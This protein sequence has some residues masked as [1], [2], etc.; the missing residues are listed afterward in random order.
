MMKNFLFTL[1]LFFLMSLPIRVLPYHDDYKHTNQSRSNWLLTESEITYYVAGERVGYINYIKVPLAPVYVLYS[2]YIYPLYRNKGL[3]KR[4]FAYVCD[5]LHGIGARR[6]YIQPGPFE[7]D[8]GNEQIDIT[9]PDRELKLKRLIRF[10][11]NN[12]FVFV[13]KAL[14]FFASF[15]YKCIGISEN[16]QYLMVKVI[17]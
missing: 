7:L 16:P 5:Y 10:Y 2:F 12:D 4:L 11:K 1:G 9:A 8:E 13:N 3:G 15:L 6:I 14:S 17:K